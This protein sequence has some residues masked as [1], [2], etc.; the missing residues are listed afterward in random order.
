[1]RI[2]YLAPEIGIPGT[3][4]GSSHVAGTLDA[5]TMLNHKVIAVVKY[6]FGQLPIQKKD[7]ILFIRVPIPPTGVL[8]NL[9]YVLYSFIISFILFLF[10]SVDLIYE[11]GR[12]FGGSGVLV[13]H[14]FH[15]KSIYEM[16]ENYL[17]VPVALG[18]I[19]SSSIRFNLMKRMHS[20]VTKKA[21]LITITNEDFKTGEGNYL[22]VHY[23]V[24][25]KR[26]S[27][28]VPAE[29]IHKKYHFTKGKTLFYIGSF[30]QWHACH[31]MI[32]AVKAV[33]AKDPEVMLLMVGEGEQ[34]ASCKEKVHAQSLQDNILLTGSL[35]YDQI[36]AHIN[37]ADICFALFD[38][39][40]PPFK[41]SQFFYSSIKI[42]EYKACGK[43]VIASD[44]GNLKKL[45]KDGI[46][47]LL[48]N[49]QRPRE[50]EQAIL[51]L[52]T[53]KNLSRKIS[54]ANRKEV[55]ERYSWDKVHRAILEAVT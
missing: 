48:V 11:R 27:P 20:T 16:N 47:G 30:A 34:W 33:I 23:G 15:K 5:L 22:L 37:A 24:N 44:F 38:R 36:P 46:N 4:G 14:W 8:R 55:L 25:T 2:L 49:E 53:N 17:H 18:K 31:S 52:I 45:V 12:I 13:A 51:K 32:D 7:N 41:K 6:R 39:R 10:R 28:D 19:D 50:I 40:Y 9:S 29:H 21:R 35:Q 43:P 54:L 3:H 42:H 26:F 1:M